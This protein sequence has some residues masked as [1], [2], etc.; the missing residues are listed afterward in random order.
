M[1]LS[2][3]GLTKDAKGIWRRAD[4]PKADLSF[5]EHGHD[6]CFAIEDNSFWFAHRT[7]CI[8]TALRSY[9]FEG[10]FL[11]IG[12]GNGAVASGL[13]KRGIPTVLLE[14]GPE[15]AHN[16]RKRGVEDV[17]CATLDEA[18][19]EP[20][21]FGGAGLFDVIE[22]V[23][24]DNALL[25]SAHRILRPHGVLC[26]TV[27]AYQLLWSAEDEHAGHYRR[28]TRKSLEQAL[29]RAGFE[30]RYSTYLFAPL[31]VPLFVFRSLRYRLGRPAKDIDANASAQHTPSPIA[32]TV[33]NAALA[34]EQHRI[35][36]QRL[37]PF[38]TSCL[39]VAT[40]R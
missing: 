15:G 10:P 40:R 23:E 21:S 33:M 28:Y 16:A 32:R 34:P 11:D 36:K 27:P 37:V 22:H 24:D 9:P 30:V 12:G 35:A 39:A 19:F 4:A 20:A 1:D 7:E 26:V 2:A 17:I 14:P 5:P 18:N 3:S 31:T 8:A 6:S 25:R 38:G 13:S 29:E